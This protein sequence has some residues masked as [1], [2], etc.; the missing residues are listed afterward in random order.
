MNK[1]GWSKNDILWIGIALI[2]PYV[3]STISYYCF[4][5]HFLKLKHKHSET[6]LKAMLIKH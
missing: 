2:V 4:E 6:A 5:L 1:L 3:A